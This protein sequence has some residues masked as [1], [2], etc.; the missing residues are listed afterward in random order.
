M[1]HAHL[2]LW[3]GRPTLYSLAFYFPTG[4]SV[5][6][7]KKQRNGSNRSI[8]FS[9]VLLRRCG[10][11]SPTSVSVTNC[12]IS[13]RLTI[14][15]LILVFFRTLDLLGQYAL[16]DKMP[17]L[18]CKQCSLNWFLTVHTIHTW[19]V[20]FFGCCDSMDAHYATFKRAE[21]AKI[22]PPPK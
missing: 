7:S 5:Q 14:R 13:Q 20:Q 12:L 19:N 3:M 8:N 4:L 11:Q 10:G 17:G 2:P 21:E 16:Y 22:L 15:N 1:R 6:R 9:L 18:R